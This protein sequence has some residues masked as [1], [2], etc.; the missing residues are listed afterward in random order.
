[1]HLL[2]IRSVEN[3]HCYKYSLSTINALGILYPK[4]GLTEVLILRRK[5]MKKYTITFAFFLSFFI[6]VT[7]FAEEDA[8]IKFYD[9]YVE[10][11]KK[12]KSINELKPYLSQYNIDQMGEITKED[13][14]LFLKIVQEERKKIKITAVSSKINGDTAILTVDGV[15]TTSNEPIDGIVYLVKENGKWKF[16]QEEFISDVVIE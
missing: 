3:Y 13:E 12:A 11:T 6:L 2:N 16:V 4:D 8:T 14:A 7:A 15:Y 10:A 9:S 1:M 5:M